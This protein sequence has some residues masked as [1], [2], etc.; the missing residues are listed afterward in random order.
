MKRKDYI[1]S[2][3]FSLYQNPDEFCFNTDTVLLAQF[4]KVNPGDE[5]LEIGTNNGV[6][7]VYLDQYPCSSL[8][9]VEI[10]ES[11]AALA[12]E[13]TRELQHPA[14][15][16]N[17]DIRKLEHPPVDLVISNPPFFKLEESGCV[18]NISMRQLGRVEYNLNLE[19]LISNASRLLKSFGRFTFLH[20]PDRLYEIMAHLKEN[21]LGLKRMAVAYDVRDNEAK[22]VLIE[23]VKD[24]YPRPKIEAPIWIGQ[25]GSKREPKSGCTQ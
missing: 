11:P 12:R 23:A 3:E 13:N 9:G 16:L 21:H 7:L 2:P 25:S 19:Q 6:L 5:I 1:I 14:V 4:I 17:E 10:L 8:T 20:R 22:A 24:F 15:I 18:E